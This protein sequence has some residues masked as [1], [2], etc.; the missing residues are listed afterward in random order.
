MKIVFNNPYSSVGIQEIKVYLS[1]VSLMKRSIPNNSR[2]KQ[3]T[4][5][6][7]KI[8]KHQKLSKEAQKYTDSK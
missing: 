8:N 3:I 2:N 7:P 1:L 4:A 6:T 5:P